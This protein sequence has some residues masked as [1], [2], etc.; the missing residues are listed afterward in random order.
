MRCGII[1]LNNAIVISC[2]D[3]AIAHHN[4][5]NG[6]FAFACCG[7]GFFKGEFHTRQIIVLH[8]DSKVW[9]TTPD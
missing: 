3:L 9:K 6:H 4:R 2:D 5:T 7:S 8:A 1:S